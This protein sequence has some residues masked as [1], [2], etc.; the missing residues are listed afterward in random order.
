MPQ[1]AGVNRMFGQGPNNAYVPIQCDA[2]GFL[3]LAGGSGVY[4]I[5]SA[6]VVK[7]VAGVAKRISVIV[8]GSSPGAIYDARTL[9]STSGRQ[10]FAIPA[11]AGVYVL[12]WPCATGISVVP[13]AGQTL[14][15][16]LA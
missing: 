8:P 16:T 11:T 10:V 12:E 15:I 7:A 9:A 3:A 5:T 1:N 2:G 4:N 6:S 13:G 14:A